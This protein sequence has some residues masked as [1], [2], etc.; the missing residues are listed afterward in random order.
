MEKIRIYRWK[1]FSVQGV[2]RYA[3]RDVKFTAANL[4]RGNTYRNDYKRGNN[5]AIIRLVAQVQEG[6]A[7][8]V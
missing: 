2:S 6:I 3:G 8:Q 1:Y 5:I 7:I 4:G